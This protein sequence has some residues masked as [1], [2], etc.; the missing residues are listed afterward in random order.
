MQEGWH[1]E[2]DD[3]D[4]PLRYSGVVYNEMKG[5]LSA[6]DDL[7]GSRIMAARSSREKVGCIDRSDNLPG[8]NDRFSNDR[9]QRAS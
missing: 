2:L 7:L 6:P 5:A 9:H 1:Y 3:A 4:A 8:R